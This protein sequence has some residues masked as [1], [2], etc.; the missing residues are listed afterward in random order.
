MYINVC[1]SRKRREK[2]EGA[3]YMHPHD[4]TPFWNAEIPLLENYMYIQHIP[5]PLTPHAPTFSPRQLSDEL[6]PAIKKSKR[7]TTHHARL[8][9]E[10][11]KRKKSEDTR[12]KKSR[13]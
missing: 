9:G 6:N 11:R 7:H 8:T 4:Y 10:K 2:E 5:P 1:M 12:K 13:Q 3:Q